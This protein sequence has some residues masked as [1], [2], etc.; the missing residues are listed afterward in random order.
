MYSMCLNNT[1]ALV[2]LHKGNWI[3]L[4][5]N[6][7]ICV[8]CSIQYRAKRPIDVNIFSLQ[9]ARAVKVPPIILLDASADW[10]KVKKGCMATENIG[11]PVF[12]LSMANL[13]FSVA[14]NFKITLP[15]LIHFFYN[16]VMQFDNIVF[17]FNSRTHC[18]QHFKT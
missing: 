6:K 9:P 12:E 3:R 14:V 4:W 16:P 13:K 5:T 10:I 7:D 18:F 1:R 2:T 11:W 8:L 17:Y 15:L